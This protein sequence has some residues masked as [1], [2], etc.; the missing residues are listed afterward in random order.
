[1]RRLL[2]MS[3]LL[4]LLIAPAAFATQASHYNTFSTCGNVHADEEPAPDAESE[5]T[6]TEE[7]EEEPDCE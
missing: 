1:M 4:T 6:S 7:T 5:E 3:C 2:I